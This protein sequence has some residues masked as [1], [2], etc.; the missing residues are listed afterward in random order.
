MEGREEVRPIDSDV[1]NVSR[2]EDM[3]TTQ[4]M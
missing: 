4:L 1:D 2:T 3:R